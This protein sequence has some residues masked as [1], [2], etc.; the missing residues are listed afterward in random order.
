MKKAEKL[1]MAEEAEM[2]AHDYDL[3]Y[4][5]CPQCV[6]AAVKETIGV[7]TDEHIKAAHTLSGG[8]G[9]K[10]IGTCG[11][12]TGGLLALGIKHGRERENFGKTRNL[13]SFDLGRKLVE[14]FAAE[15][16]AITCN[17]IQ[18]RFTGRTYDMWNA[19]EIKEFKSSKCGP[20]CAMLTGN[21]AKWVVELI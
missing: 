15:Y 5:S 9:L 6:L 1:K 20:G 19:K 14:R 17:E 4:G 12:L 13:K 8:G 3:E 7:V 2:I 18:L 10:G 11:A 16:E 21:V